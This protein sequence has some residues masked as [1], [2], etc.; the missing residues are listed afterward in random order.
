[1]F[2]RQP[3]LLS[4]TCRSEPPPPSTAAVGHAAATEANDEAQAAVIVQSVPCRSFPLRVQLQA[5]RR[6]P[7]HRGRSKRMW[8]CRV[9]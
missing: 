1:M 2:F 9:R 4:R 6:G 5:R 8:G 3:G 7:L